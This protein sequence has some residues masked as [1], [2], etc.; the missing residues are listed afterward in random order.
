[1]RL[2]VYRREAYAYTGGKAFDAGLPCVVFLHGALHDHS[3]WTLLARW[4]AHHGHS[5]LAVDLPGHGR[6]TGPLLPT[7]QAHADWTLALLAAA[8]VQQPGQA[9]LVGHSMGSLVALEAAA[10]APALVGRLVMVGSTYPMKVSDALLATAKTAP[11]QAIDMVNAFSIST[12]AAK[13]SYPAPGMWLHGSNRALMRRVLAGA[14]AAGA[15]D[16]AGK[17]VINLFHHDF[18]LCDQY[19][20]GLQ[21]AALV[22]AQATLVL[23]AQDQMTPARSSRDLAAALRA[24]TVTLPAGHSIAAEDPDG[25]LAALRQALA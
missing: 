14:N 25:L 6:S 5:V 10:R 17:A 15:L 22:Q 4:C 12:L 1:M 9:T 7:L 24:R 23:G 20:N 2:Q 18:S 13:P 3:V 21:A 16:A 11:L 8:G 19:S